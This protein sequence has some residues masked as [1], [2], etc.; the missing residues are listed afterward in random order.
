MYVVALAV[1]CLSILAIPKVALAEPLDPRLAGVDRLIADAV[2]RRVFP[3]AV[4]AVGRS[5]GVIHLRAFGSHTYDPGSPAMG[6]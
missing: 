4:V 3:G 6:V 5:D 1:C 2:S